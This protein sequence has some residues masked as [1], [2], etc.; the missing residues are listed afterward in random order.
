MGLKTWLN[1]RREKKETQ[2]RM[3]ELSEEDLQKLQVTEK[4]A[5]LNIAKKQV[6]YRGKINAYRDFPIDTSDKIDIDNQFKKE[7][8]EEIDEEKEEEE[9]EE[10]INESEI[11]KINEK[12]I[13]LDDRN[14]AVQQM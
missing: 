8:E 3:E 12:E 6:T 13:N 9:I 7:K 4:A 5:Y 11:N 10:E 2:K 1:D 14:P